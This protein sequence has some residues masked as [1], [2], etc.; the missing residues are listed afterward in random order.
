MKVWSKSSLL[1][2]VEEILF[3]TMTTRCCIQQEQHRKKKLELGWSVVH[4]PAYS[5][6]LTPTDYYLSRSHQNDL[7]G[8]RFSLIKT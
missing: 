6:G 2:S 3:F 8:G 5:T 1:L 4:H 7:M